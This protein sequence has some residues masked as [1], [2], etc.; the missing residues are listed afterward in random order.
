MI[1]DLHTHLTRALRGS[2]PAEKAA[3]LIEA[4]DRLGIERFCVY[5]GIEWK[6]DPDPDNIPI[7]NDDILYSLQVHAAMREILY[8]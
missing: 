4:G 8:R 3:H 7:Q 1:W 6:R 5:M 2:A